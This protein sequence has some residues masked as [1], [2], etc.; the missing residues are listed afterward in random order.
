MC[1]HVCVCEFYVCV[2]TLARIWG[3]NMQ[4]ERKSMGGGWYLSK[5]DLEITG[6]FRYTRE[7]IILVRDKEK[8]KSGA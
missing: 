6:N 4:M 7:E 5:Q 1:V 3:V 2:C 8:V